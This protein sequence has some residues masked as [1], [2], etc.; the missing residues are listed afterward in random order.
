VVEDFVNAKAMLAQSPAVA[1]LD[2]SEGHRGEFLIAGSRLAPR[3]P[4]APMA[5]SDTYASWG[6]DSV[7]VCRGQI[8]GRRGRPDRD[9]RGRLLA[10]TPVRARR[11]RRLERWQPARD[12]F[13]QLNTGLTCV[14]QIPIDRHDAPLPLA[15]P[16]STHRF[17][18]TVRQDG[19]LNCRAHAHLRRARSRIG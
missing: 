11:R 5:G 7:A 6:L 17:R 18:P 19:N 1:R 4:E 12:D 15:G 13:G 8:R 14:A 16:A 3:P 9:L 2:V 10:T